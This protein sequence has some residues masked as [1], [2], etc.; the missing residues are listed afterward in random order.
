MKA[1]FRNR[2]FWQVLGAILLG[3]LIWFIGPM[4]AIADWRPLG[5]WPVTLFFAL[6]PLLVMGGLWWWGLRKERRQNAA[7][8]D[9]LKP[10]EGAADRDEIA[11]KLGEAL[12]MLKSTKLGSRR[13]KAYQLPWYVVIGPSGAG[14][15]T[16][17]LN[18]GLNFPTAVAG[19]YRALRGQPKTPNCDWWFTDEAVLIDTA[20]RYVTQDD[21][22]AQDAGSSST[23]RSSRSTA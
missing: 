15:T 18:C 23:V 12:D 21:N 8:L 10:H 4:I 3:L 6:L 7:M 17:L 22:A 19:E 5:W 2:L 9:A 14:K 1:L 11:A 16:S 20:G 13:T